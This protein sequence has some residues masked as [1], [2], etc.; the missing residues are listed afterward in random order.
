M[1]LI[2]DTDALLWMSGDSSNLGPGSRAAVT[3]A[4]SIG[5]LKFSAISMLE[6]TRLHWDGRIDLRRAPELWYRDLLDLGVHEIPITS[7]MAI[8]AGSLERRDGFHADPA[9]QL[10]AAAA[11]ITRSRL[12]T[13]D[14]KILRWAEG[15]AALDCLNAR[16]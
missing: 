9:D 14:R 10:V 15:R 6:I 2:L 7:E 3:Q 1:N 5:S 16:S 13:S 12:V 8:L 11:I 4:A